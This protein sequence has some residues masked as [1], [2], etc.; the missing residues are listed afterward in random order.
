MG[1]PRYLKGKVPSSIPSM[2]LNSL[3]SSL[4]EPEKKTLLF[5]LLYLRL[6]L[7]DRRKLWKELYNLSISHNQHPWIIMGD[8]NVMRNSNEKLQGSHRWDSYGD[9]LNYC[10]YKVELDDLKEFRTK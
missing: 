7:L 4:D 8:F 6:D 2:R 3:L 9:N 10:C 1:T 5:A